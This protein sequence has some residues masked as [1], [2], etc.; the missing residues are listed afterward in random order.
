MI[1]IGVITY[2]TVYKKYD[3]G[4]KEIIS[5]NL[6]IT[7]LVGIVEAVFFLHIALKFV[8]VTTTDLMTDLIDRTEY[9]INK[10]LS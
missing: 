8:P 2:F 10:Q 1:I 3:I 7:V 9:K 4:L 5:E 6:V